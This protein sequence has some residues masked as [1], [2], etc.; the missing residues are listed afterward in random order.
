MDSE[1]THS[2]EDRAGDKYYQHEL[3]LVLRQTTGPSHPVNGRHGKVGGSGEKGMNGFWSSA[4]S[5]MHFRDGLE[6]S[7][8]TEGRNQEAGAAHHG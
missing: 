5:T 4:C 7:L 1:S 3:F 8:D 2:W 6:N